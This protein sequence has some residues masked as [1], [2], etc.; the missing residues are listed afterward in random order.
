MQARYFRYLFE[1]QEDGLIHSG[2]IYDKI[3]EETTNIIYL[4]GNY[5]RMEPWKKGKSK[6]KEYK[7]PKKVDILVLSDYTTLYVKKFL[8]IIKNYEVDT[9]ILPYLAPVQRLILLMDIEPKSIEEKN[10]SRFLR[11]PYHYLKELSIPNIY[12][13]YG[14]AESN[15]TSP[16]EWES[17][18]HF[19]A[20]DPD[21][22][23]LVNDME[24][25]YMPVVR[26]GYVIKNR[27][28]FYFGCYGLDM[29]VLYSFTREYFGRLESIYRFCNRESEVYTWQI[30]KLKK[31]YKFKFKDAPVTTVAM[32]EGPLDCSAQEND[33]FMVEKEF[34][35]KQACEAWMGKDSNP[36]NCEIKCIYSKDYDTMQ[37][38][39]D[40]KRVNTRFGILL[41]GN[42]NLNRFLP[43]IVTRFWEL[44]ERIRV[45]TVPNSGAEEEWSKQALVFSSPQD[46]VYWL[47]CKQKFTSSDVVSD[48]VLTNPGNRFINVP[49]NMGSC[50][51]GYLIPR[52][53]SVNL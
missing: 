47:C 22:Q 7:I 6:D 44:R 48:I 36:C 13:L 26:A 46:R 35:D 18:N 49:E 9:V 51:S 30:K 39:K 1:N 5:N 27:W 8:S 17:G 42:I 43:E 31:D 12:F 28:L 4:A 16:E 32:F 14:N 41:L 23:R 24:G 10:A 50:F 53:E 37:S 25:Y 38:H 40:K 20:A 15:Q 34:S 33:S 3:E 52:D 2:C 21:A 11:E 19:E 29:K 45:I